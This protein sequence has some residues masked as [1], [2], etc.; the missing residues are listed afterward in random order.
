MIFVGGNKEENEAFIIGFFRFYVFINQVIIGDRLISQNL[1][2][3][4]YQDE[5]KGVFLDMR[6]G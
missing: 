4:I 3:F 6:Q 1:F 2:L 5:F